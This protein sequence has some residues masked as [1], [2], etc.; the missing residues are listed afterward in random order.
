MHERPKANDH[1]KS[2]R[3]AGV[4]TLETETLHLDWPRLELAIG[5]AVELRLLDDGEGDAPGEVHKSSESPTNLFSS[6]D[7]ANELLHLVSEFESRLMELVDKAEKTEP[8]EEHK[9]LTQAVG[10]VFHEHGKRLLYPV[11][12]RHKELTPE[13]LKGE[14]L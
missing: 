12:R 11:Y 1:T 8:A 6:A 4:R 13:D 2:I 3:I 10:Y 14:P 5:D 7:L 9:K